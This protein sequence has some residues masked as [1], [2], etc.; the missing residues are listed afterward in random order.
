M[1]IGEPETSIHATAVVGDGVEIGR[2]VTIGPYSIVE[3]GAILRD[4]CRLDAHVHVHGCADVGEGT[5]IRSGSVVGGEPQDFKYKGETSR[6]RIGKR[7]RLHECVTIN[8]ATGEG[9]ETVVG[10]EVMFMAG[11]HVGH[12]CVIDN[13]ATLVNGVMLGGHCHIGE[14]A[15]LSGNSAVHQFC[16][17]GR[18]T[19]VGGACMVTKDAPPFSIVVGQ[20]PVHWR[21]P[22]T[23][24]MRRA[25][26][27]TDQR[28]AIRRALFQLFRT[29]DS[30]REEAERLLASPH[31]EV[32]EIARFVLDS[33]RGICAS[34]DMA[35]NR[36]GG[37]AS[38]D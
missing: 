22:N 13:G 25:G 12:N 1:S 20:Y 38:E 19:L 7:C 30:R 23:I 32:V 11:T 36:A 24:G 15:L 34:P 18:L 16:R 8:R 33:E 29:K 14:R 37:D 10:D 2:G 26:F 4:G 17:V 27:T 31:S 28:S 9:C 21:A 5:T 3:S 35:R 6:L